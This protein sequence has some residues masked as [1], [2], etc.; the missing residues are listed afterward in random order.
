MPNTGTAGFDAAEIID[1]LGEPERERPVIVEVTTR[2]VVWVEDQL[3]TEELQEGGY[4]LLGDYPD[5]IDTSVRVEDPGRWD[6]DEIYTDTAGPENAPVEG[7]RWQCPACLAG[8]PAWATW[9]RRH[10]AWCAEVG[11]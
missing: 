6:W 4:D 9:E 7:P 3:T 10:H 8:H 2:Y 1:L 11:R 5:S